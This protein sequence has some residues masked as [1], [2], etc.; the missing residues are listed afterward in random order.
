MPLVLIVEDNDKNLRLTQDILE[1]G[2]FD[3]VAARTGE[4][5]VLLARERH[6]DVILM[7][8]QL[9]GM[10]GYAALEE[11]RGDNITA[12]IPVVA[13]TAFAMASDRRR[14][15]EAGFDRYVSKPIDVDKLPEDIHLACRGVREHL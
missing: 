13:L 10:D 3:T 9:P 1:Y 6:P 2:G 15:L 11:L 7:D 4:E 8:I 5:G 14:A 12:G